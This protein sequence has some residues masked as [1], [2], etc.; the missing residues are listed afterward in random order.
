M[1]YIA[2]VYKVR[3]KGHSVK[4]HP[5]RHRQETKSHWQ[6]CVAYKGEAS[7]Y[8]RIGLFDSVLRR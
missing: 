3:P 4:D 1:P 8:M 2:V 5:Q 7:D 6:H